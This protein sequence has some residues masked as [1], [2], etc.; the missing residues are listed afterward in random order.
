MRTEISEN[1]Q[2]IWMR[3]TKTLEGL[4]CTNYAKDG[5][6]QRIITVLEDALN[7]ANGEL[8]CSDHADSMANV[9]ASTT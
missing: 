7:Q 8:L 3:D 6:Q 5:T 1:G 2:V 4:A 9:G